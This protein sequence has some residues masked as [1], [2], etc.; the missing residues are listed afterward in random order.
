LGI[1][2]VEGKSMKNNQYNYILGDEVKKVR[3]LIEKSDLSPMVA[4]NSVVERFKNGILVGREVVFINPN[5]DKVGGA[6]TQVVKKHPLRCVI[7]THSQAYLG[8]NKL[9]TSPVLHYGTD[10]LF[11]TDPSKQRVV[12]DLD[13]FKRLSEERNDYLHQYELVENFIGRGNKNEFLLVSVDRDAVIHTLLGGREEGMKWRGLSVPFEVLRN[14]SSGSI[15]KEED[16]VVSHN[17]F[18]DSWGAEE[19]GNQLKEALIKEIG[20]S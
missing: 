7:D 8:K 13:A 2:K 19:V 4:I 14:I 18:L 5:Y 1:L 3:D 11:K 12:I 17:N 10:F 16:I 9:Q 6:I 20:A 15:F